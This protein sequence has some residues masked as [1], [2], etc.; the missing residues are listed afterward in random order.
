MVSASPVTVPASSGPTNTSA[1]T[2]IQPESATAK[3]SVTAPGS[4]APYTFYDEIEIDDMD[5]DPDEETYYYPC[6]CG[7]RFAIS[8]ESL[9][10]GDFVGRC[11]SCTLIIKVIF[12]PDELE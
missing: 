8:K 1:T 12:D 7:D 11:L 9:I 6:P 10:A 5:Y 4:E 2:A 3:A